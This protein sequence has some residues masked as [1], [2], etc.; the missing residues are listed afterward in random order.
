MNIIKELK[1]FNTAEISDALDACGVE[2]ALLNIKPLTED[3]IM[4]GRAFTVKY[5]PYV[6]KPESF[7]NGGNY[8]DDVPEDS[9]I[10]IDNNGRSDCTT[11]GDILTEVAILKKIGGTL[12]H[13]AVRDIENIKKKKYPI[14]ANY[15]YMRSG[16]NRVYKYDQQCEISIEGI[17]IKPNDII[18]G[19]QNGA[20]VIPQHL[21]NE[22]IKKATRIKS[23]EEN[24]ILSVR[25]GLSL[26]EARKKY[27]YDQPW[28]NKE[29]N[30]GT[31][32]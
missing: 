15:V 27:R 10:V 19:D 21:I 31:E 4:I 18:M 25:V 12:V 11:W 22:V 16:K 2:G 20:L 23:T 7:M 8:I 30:N 9:I 29:E 3:A 28:L 32:L 1:Q 24:I 5:M 13:G 14:F 26:E 17:K 6:S